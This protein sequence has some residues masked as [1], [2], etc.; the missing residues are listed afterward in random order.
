DVACDVMGAGYSSKGCS[1]GSWGYPDVDG[2]ILG[3][4]A[5]G[6]ST[7]NS[8]K[9]MQFALG[10]WP[11]GTKPDPWTGD[12]GGGGGG[13]CMDMKAPTVK[14]TS[15]A[16]GATVMPSFDVLVDAADDCAMKNVHIE[17]PE[18]GLK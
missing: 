4:A 10:M 1:G 2:T 12:P 3:G 13:G 18:D 16:D 14:I 7:Q 6:A 11:G 15:P 5:C 9:R 8:Y 17:I